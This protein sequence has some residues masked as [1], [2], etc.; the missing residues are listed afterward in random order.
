MTVTTIPDTGDPAADAAPKKKRRKLVLILLAVVVLAAAGAWFFVL[1]PSGDSAPQPGAVLPLDEKQINLAGGHYL[2]VG[3]A[4]Q[5]TKDA[6]TEV[7][8]SKALD[9]AI[10]LFT[11]RS[12]ASVDSSRTRNDLKRQLAKQL[13]KEYDGEVMGVYFTEF[14]TQ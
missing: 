14:V 10:D 9:A 4:L 5:L 7:D 3:L 13:A 2:R 1:K 8:G 6:G 11:G 12:V